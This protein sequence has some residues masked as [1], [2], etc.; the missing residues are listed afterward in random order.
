MEVKKVKKVKL[1]SDSTPDANVQ[2]VFS[3]NNIKWTSE[4][5]VDGDTVW[6]IN[7]KDYISLKVKYNDLVEEYYENTD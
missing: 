1:D 6:S 2:D 7:R 3:D 5:D 4:K